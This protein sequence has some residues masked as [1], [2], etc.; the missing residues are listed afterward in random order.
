MDDRQD[1]RS[2]AIV[3]AVTEPTPIQKTATEID[4]ILET[5]KFSIAQ[6][7]SINSGKEN[8]IDSKNLAKK[9]RTCMK[10][11]KSSKT[12]DEGKIKIADF[13][14]NKLYDIFRLPFDKQEVIVKELKN[15]IF[16]AENMPVPLRLYYLKF[17]NE[18]VP[19][20]VSV[21]L[22]KQ[23]V[24]DKMRVIPYFQILKY[25]LKSNMTLRKDEHCEAILDEFEKLFNNEKVSIYTKME[26]ADVFLLNNRKERAY[27]MLNYL[28]DLEYNMIRN[29]Y[30]TNNAT[31]YQRIQTV[32]GDSQNVHGTELNDSVMKSCVYLMELE[33]PN[34]FNAKEVKEILTKMS[35][36]NCDTINTVLERIEIDT[37]RF[38]WKDN[39]FGLYD[40]FSSLWFYIKKHPASSELY[41]RLIEEI[42]AMAKYCTTGHVSRFINV[43]QGYTDDEKLCVRISYEQQIK[44]VVGHYLDMMMLNASEDVNEAMIGDDKQPFYDFITNKMNDR[45]PQL[46]KEYGEVQEEI[47]NVIKI[48]STW[49]YWELANQKLR[50]IP[51]YS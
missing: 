29:S 31:M 21:Q 23:G 25:I 40:V 51:N 6:P 33:P 41:M 12:S 45:I 30:D 14:C 26:I 24:R 39:R 13:I 46:L 22:F 44:S 10:V 49:N 3:L 34:G 16:K 15:V 37:S 28:R 20:T 4:D 47:I 17:R 50:W 35:P 1:T 5:D 27:E 43:I 42:S 48:Y 8:I 19:Y 2:T 9:I 36:Q 11:L 32:Y 7:N 18:Y 38:I